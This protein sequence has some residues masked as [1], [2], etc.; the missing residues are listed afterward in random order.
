MFFFLIVDKNLI[1]EL[2][3]I[4]QESLIL[5]FDRAIFFFKL[6]DELISLVR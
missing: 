4:E 3:V 6:G 2:V 1:D 5:G